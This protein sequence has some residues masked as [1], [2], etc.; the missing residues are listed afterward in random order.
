MPA[1]SIANAMVFLMKEQGQKRWILQRPQLK[2]NYSRLL[3]VFVYDVGRSTTTLHDYHNLS[4]SRPVD[5]VPA[6]REK[7]A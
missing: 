2:L 6:G 5:V 1:L 4:G 7:T 3:V